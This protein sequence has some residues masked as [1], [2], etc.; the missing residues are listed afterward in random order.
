MISNFAETILRNCKKMR[1]LLSDRKNGNSN[2]MKLE[3]IHEAFK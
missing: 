3:K 1:L 2:T